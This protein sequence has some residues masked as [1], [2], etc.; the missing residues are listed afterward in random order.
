LFVRD[1]VLVATRSYPQRTTLPTRDVLTAFLAQFYAGGKVVPPEILV[2]EE[3]DDVAGVEEVL[4]ALREAR[5][6]VRVPQRGGGRDLLAMAVENAALSLA[7]HRTATR[8]AAAALGALATR[9]G[10]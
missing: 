7:E 8:T 10:L 6:E 4:S 5:V 3:P 1:G 9:L 2:M